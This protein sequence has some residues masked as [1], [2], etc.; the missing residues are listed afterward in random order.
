MRTTR[1]LPARAAS[2]SAFRLAEGRLRLAGS[3]LLA[4]TAAGEDAGRAA[5]TNTI[6]VL[7]GHGTIE[8]KAASS[9]Q[10]VVPDVLQAVMALLS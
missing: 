6:M 7:T 1:T 2:M 3:A 10:L 8:A 4:A 9:D 5:G